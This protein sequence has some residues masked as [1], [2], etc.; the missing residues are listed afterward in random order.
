MSPTIRLLWR[1]RLRGPLRRAA[2]LALIVSCAGG[3]CLAVAAG[4]RRTENAYDHVVALTNGGELGSSYVTDD[5]NDVDGVADVLDVLPAVA[6]HSQ[7]V[8]FQVAVDDSPII[9]LVS[10]AYYNDPVVVERPILSAGRWPT[11]ADEVFVNEWAAA[12]GHLSIGDRLDAIVAN[13]DFSLTSRETLEV[14]GIGILSDEIYEDESSSKPVFIFA[15]DFVAAHPGMAV[16]R[17][18]R[19]TQTR[20]WPSGS[21]GADAGTRC[22]HRR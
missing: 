2:A 22:R 14:V 5:P 3:V 19:H 10:F 15:K 13:L 18:D 21:D 20:R 1:S 11:E 6:E 9:G 17:C 8:G 12:Q 4:A 7:L 16:G